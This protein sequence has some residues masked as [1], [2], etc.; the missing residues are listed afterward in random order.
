MRILVLGAGEGAFEERLLDNGYTNIVAIDI[1]PREEYPLAQKVEYYQIDLNTDFSNNFTIK[2]D[3]IIAIEVIEHLYNPY[4]FLKN[5]SDLLSE[6]GILIVTT[7]NVHETFARLLF[8]FTGLITWFGDNVKSPYDHISVIPA[9]VFY[10][11][12]KRA[13]LVV[14]E[15]SYNRKWHECIIIDSKKFLMFLPFGL[16]FYA[17]L[18]LVEKITVKNEHRPL[19]N[20]VINIFVLKKI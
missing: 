14:L 4:S 5:A 8:L 20:G 17:L 6:N 10:E 11:L 18:K 2:F 12:S 15:R 1:L 7:P 3:V 19:T 16:V 13:G 9:N